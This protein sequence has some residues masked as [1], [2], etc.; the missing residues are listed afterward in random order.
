MNIY[1]S[2]E[3]VPW[4]TRDVIVMFHRTDGNNKKSVDIKLVK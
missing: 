1:S 3:Y 2:I 4:N